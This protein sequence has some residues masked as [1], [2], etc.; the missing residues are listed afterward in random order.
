MTLNMGLFI[1]DEKEE[2]LLNIYLFRGWTYSIPAGGMDLMTRSSI[3]ENEKAYKD[4][5]VGSI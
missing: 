2:I 4:L 1:A 5:I 3:C